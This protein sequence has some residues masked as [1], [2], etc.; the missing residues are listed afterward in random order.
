MAGA[1]IFLGAKL[2]N[3]GRAGTLLFG[4]P[5][6]C[7]THH[8]GDRSRWYLHVNVDNRILDS[9]KILSHL[10]GYLHD[11]F[12]HL[13]HR[14]SLICMA[15]TASWNHISEPLIELESFSC[16]S[17][18]HAICMVCLHDICSMLDSIPPLACYSAALPHVAGAVTVV[19][20][21]GC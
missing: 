18:V 14:T 21:T 7:K 17:Y 9:K 1:E 15:F 5:K 19:D 11:I 16:L 20:G 3:K 12:G 8:F 10:H 4:M 13:K 2:L 6:G